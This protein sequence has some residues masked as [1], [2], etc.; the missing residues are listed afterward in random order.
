MSD[1]KHVAADALRRIL[2]VPLSDV[3][4]MFAKVEA[5]RAKLDT[6][7]RHDFKKSQPGDPNVTMQLGWRC[8]HCG[9]ELDAHTVRWYATGLDHGKL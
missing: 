2:G 3:N 9:G 8:S 7:R 1:K 5:N 4:E 6:C